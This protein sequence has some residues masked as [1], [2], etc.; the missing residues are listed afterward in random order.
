MSGGKPLLWAVAFAVAGAV[1]GCKSDDDPGAAF[2]GR[3]CDVYKPCCTAA[4]L[5]G[6]GQACRALFA[7]AASPRAKY[8]GTAGEACLAGLQQSA[9]QPGFCEGDIVPPSACAQAFGGSGGNACIQDSDCPPSA[10]GDVRCVSGFVGGATVRKCQVQSRGQSGSTPCVGSV[11]GNVTLYGGS[12][13]GDIPDQGFLCYADD[14]LR[15]DGSACVALAAAGTACELSSDCAG[16]AFCDA[17]TGL[18]AARK[19]AGAACIG[20]ALECQ[21]GSY[22]DETAL[23]CAAQRDMGSACSDNIQCLTGNCPDGTCQPTPPVGANP[24]CG[25]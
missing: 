25:G 10:Q 16:A 1:L 24:V 9:G 13:A 3:Y 22:C 8:D 11:R 17:S 6:D 12:G 21:D 15:C 4:G 18:C 7:S 2:I 14:G 19:A 5:P 20:Q 23:M